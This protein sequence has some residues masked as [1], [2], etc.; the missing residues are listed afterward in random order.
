MNKPSKCITGFTLIELL[1][2]IMLTATFLLMASELFTSNMLTMRD[3]E[4]DDAAVKQF[5]AIIG[6]LRRD[7]W[8]S[9][10]I[11]VESSTS[12]TL[13]RGSN[14]AVQWQMAGD[15]SLGRTRLTDATPVANSW[16]NPGFTVTFSRDGCELVAF[17]TEP[18]GAQAQELR[19][20]SQPL[21]LQEVSR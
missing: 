9:D 5:D 12:V 16:T 11:S 14:P 13:S 1:F 18:N 21:W 20:V 4:A 8:A 19:L 7:V 3:A 2:V 17:I 6:E 15:G 10:E